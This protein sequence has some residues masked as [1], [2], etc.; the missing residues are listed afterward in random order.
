MTVTTYRVEGMSCD[1]CKN[2]VTQELGGLEGVSLVDVDLAAGTATVTSDAEL[3]V[4]VV[5]EAIDEAGY[6][7]VDA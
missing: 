4:D 1:H 7:L 2:A 3:T 5:R 6:T